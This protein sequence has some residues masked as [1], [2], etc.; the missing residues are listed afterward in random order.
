MAFDIN[1]SDKSL[2]D[3]KEIR[4]YNARVKKKYY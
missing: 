2:L 4:D 1:F 3:I